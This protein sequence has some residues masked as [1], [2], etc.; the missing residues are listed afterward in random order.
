M[1]TT[2]HLKKVLPEIKGYQRKSLYSI[3]KNALCYTLSEMP[4]RCRGTAIECIIRDHLITM[5]FRVNHL[6]GS[7]C[8]DMMVDGLGVEVKSSL[9]NSKISLKTGKV[10][11]YYNFQ[12]IKTNCFDYLVLVF[13]QPKCLLIRML[14]REQAKYATRF[15]ING[16]EG[17]SLSLNIDYNKIPGE[18]FEKFWKENF[19][20][21]EA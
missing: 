7:H 21:V 19:V 13:V 15:N 5:G 8:V 11:Y 14:T 17:K 3:R 10:S 18:S 1:F 12:N 4:S 2:K 20:Q 6:G 16:R 9:A